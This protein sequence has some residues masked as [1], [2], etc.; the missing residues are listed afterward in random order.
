MDR[1]SVDALTP[2]DTVKALKQFALLSKRARR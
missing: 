1:I 2:D